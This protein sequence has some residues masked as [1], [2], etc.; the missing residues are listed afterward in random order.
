MLE[1]LI[2]EVFIHGDFTCDN[3]GLS[4][5]KELVVFDFQHGCLGPKG[6]DKAYIASTLHYNKCIFELNEQEKQIAETIAAIRYG[7]AI[8]KNDDIQR[9][10]EIFVSWI[11][12]LK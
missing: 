3:L 6:W 2:P 1:G 7:R 11:N 12:R 4:S 8:R 9:R 5:T 10:K